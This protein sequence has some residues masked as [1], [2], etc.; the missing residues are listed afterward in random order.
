MRIS[1]TLDE[2]P[3]L[4][5]M[6]KTGNSMPPAKEVEPV[7]RFRATRCTPDRALHTE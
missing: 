3:R 1:S 6:C 5:A 4:M 2:N 7:E